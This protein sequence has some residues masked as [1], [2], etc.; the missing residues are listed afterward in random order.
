M[1]HGSF[2]AIIENDT[3]ISY[4]TTLLLFGGSK[5]KNVRRLSLFPTVSLGAEAAIRDVYTLLAL[6]K[7]DK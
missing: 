7:G 1:I 3:R 5:L 6:A 4:H 2:L